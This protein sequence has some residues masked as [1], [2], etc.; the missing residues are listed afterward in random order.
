MT[1]DPTGAALPVPSPFM[2]TCD[3]CWQLLVLLAKRVREDAGCF[4]EQ[5]NLA[6]HIAAAHPDEVPKPHGRN[7]PLCP[8]YAELPADAGNWAQHRARDLFL[9]EHVA[10]LL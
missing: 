2:F 7:C 4:T 1:Y 8:K 5:V 10:R 9:P 3:G 6:R